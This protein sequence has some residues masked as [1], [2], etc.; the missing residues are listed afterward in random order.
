MKIVLAVLAVGA[1]LAPFTNA[2]SQGRRQP[3]AFRAASISSASGEVSLTGGG[4]YD[5]QF[6]V[7]EGGGEFRSKTDITQGPL[8]GCRAGEGLHWKIDQLLDSSGFKCGGSAAEPL[9]TVVTDGQTIV[10]QAQFF[11]FGDGDRPSFTAKIFVSAVDQ[12][13]DAPGIQNVWIQGVGCGEATTN[14]Q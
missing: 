2:E 6:R 12:D 1:L 5:P 14:L 7:A 9:K 13:P 3:F 10:A 4:T 8:A 11:R